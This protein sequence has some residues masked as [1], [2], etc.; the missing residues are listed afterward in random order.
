M[1]SGAARITSWQCQRQ[2][3]RNFREFSL[4]PLD[5][6]M[7]TWLDLLSD[8]LNKIA[9]ENKEV[10]VLDDFNVDLLKDNEQARSWQD[11]MENEYDFTQL[12]TEP[13]RVT[14]VSETL[15]DHIFVSH[16]D[17]ITQSFVANYS[18][19]DHFP[20]CV[21]RKTSVTSKKNVGTIKYRFFKN[22]Y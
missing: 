6:N 9:R 10:I 12:I 19:S 18:I 7:T 4:P 16:P 11:Y 15:I 21:T 20:R 22:S 8:S 3:I 2:S 13:N 5:Q 14:S 17:N 1:K